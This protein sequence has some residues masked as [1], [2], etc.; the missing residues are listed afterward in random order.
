MRKLLPAILLTAIAVGGCASDQMAASSAPARS[1]A[2]EGSAAALGQSVAAGDLTLT[3]VTVKE[4]SR[5]AAGTQCIWA[6]RLVLSTR[7]EG[8]GWSE[9]ADLIAGEPKTVHGRTVLL[10]SALPDRVAGDGI[11]ASEY[12][13]TF[14]AE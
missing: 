9:T 5:C 1:A 13:F 4:D 14:A 11:A 2:P 7:V 12:R 8:A 10:V 3:P 6:G